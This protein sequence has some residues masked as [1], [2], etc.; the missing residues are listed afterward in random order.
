MY[1]VVFHHAAG[2][3]LAAELAALSRHGL[4]VRV[5]APSDRR[6]L[7]EAL[8]DAVLLWRAAGEPVTVTL[9]A[10]APRLRLVQALGPGAGAGAV[11]LAAARAQGIAVCAAPGADTPAVAEMALALTFACLRRL[12]ALDRA[13]R[14]ALWPA[15]GGPAFGEL[16]GRTIG[17]VGYG[18]VPARLAPALKALGATVVYWHRHREPAADATFVPLRELIETSDVVSL[19][20][21]PT[22]ETERLVDAAALGLMKPGSVLVNTAHA[23]LVDEAALVDAL[24]SKHLGAAGLDV[25]ATHPLPRE[26]PLLGLANVVLSPGMA[27]RTPPRRCAARS[28][29]RSR[30]PA[31]CATAGRCCTGSSELGCRRR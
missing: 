14:T 17:L 20:L 3:D 9:L 21:P 15:E 18:P 11:D 2:R 23:G 27:G 22:P 12:P 7:S 25:L 10:E 19:H 28:L 30:T 24:A 8:A 6:R 13:S 29:W 1:P 16:A 26:H 4:Q 5:V 31:G